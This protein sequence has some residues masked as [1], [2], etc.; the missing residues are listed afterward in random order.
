MYK[1]ELKGKIVGICGGS[2]FLG[3]QIVKKL[4]ERGAVVLAPRSNEYDFRKEE[5][6]ERF[7]SD[8]KMDAFIHSGAIYGGLGI[9][10]RMP[11]DIYDIN[12]RMALNA[13]KAAIDSETETPRVEKMIA[14]GSACG[15]PSALGTDMREELMWNGPIDKSVRNYGTIKKLMETIGHVYRDQYGL[16]AINLQLATLYGEEDTFNPERSHVPAAL[17]RKFVEA[18]DRN[19][20]SV[21]LWGVPDTVR[22]FMYVKDCAEGIV[23]ALE[24]FKGD[25]ETDNQSKYTL[26][27][28]TGDAVTIDE[29]A[30]TIKELVGFKGELEYNGKSPGQKE[31]ALEV[32]RM[33]R[34]LGWKPPTTLKEGLKKALGWYI[35]N[36]DAADAR[37]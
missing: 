9:N 22:E 19:E 2:G 4:E 21:E 5:D 8:N 25:P 34:V 1:M 18:K 16:N 11:A 33:K 10:E 30:T 3:K 24:S 35:P 13:F 36:K 37:N 6:A 14:I 28:G 27:L 12:M 20:S 23:R 17:M 32:S 29:L 7:F 31:K 15:Y 26:N